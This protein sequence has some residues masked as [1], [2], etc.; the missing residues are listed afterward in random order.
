MDE[1]LLKWNGDSD[2]LTSNENDIMLNLNWNCSKMCRI[3]LTDAPTILCN[4]YQSI[5][6]DEAIASSTGSLTK[7]FC[8]SEQ[9]SL[10]LKDIIDIFVKVQVYTSNPIL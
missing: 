3:C 10:K 2:A 7:E 1:V 6:L 8:G 5:E 9:Q 4:L